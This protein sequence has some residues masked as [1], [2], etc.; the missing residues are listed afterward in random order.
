[1]S[2][3]MVVAAVAAAG[4]VGF[5]SAAVATPLGL[6]DAADSVPG[7]SAVKDRVSG[8][9]AQTQEL[10]APGQA[11]LSGA[12]SQLRGQLEGG[13][14][15]LDPQSADVSGEQLAVSV[16]DLATKIRNGSG[17]LSAAQ[18]QGAERLAGQLETAA[19]KLRAASLQDYMGGG[20]ASGEVS[21]EGSGGSVNGSGEMS[22][23]GGTVDGAGSVSAPEAFAQ[24]QSALAQAQQMDQEDVLGGSAGDLLDRESAEAQLQRV[25]GQLSG[26]LG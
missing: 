12:L 18:A 11:Q 23:D 20:N 25:A 3:K 14:L 21:A 17:Q 8:G 9:V 15:S 5:G 22:G 1:M 7:V 19:G 2:R 16:E 6:D 4:V 13:Q 10:D 26:L 24:L